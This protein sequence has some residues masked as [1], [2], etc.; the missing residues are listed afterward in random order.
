MNDMAEIVESA[1]ASPPDHQRAPLY[2]ADDLVLSPKFSECLAFC[3]D[4]LLTLHRQIPR[5]VRYVA[6][7]RRWIMTHG[8]LALNFSH[9][10]NPALPALSASNLF[11]EISHTGIA[12]PNTVTSYL[13]EIHARGYIQLL[14]GDD[15]R[16]RAYCMTEFSERMFYLYLRINLQ[17]LNKI[18]GLGRDKDADANPLILTLMH[19]I[20]ARLMLNDQNY[21]MPPPSIA[22][23]VNTTIGISI[24]NEMTRD[25]KSEPPEK[26][27]RIRVQMGSASSMAKHY[28]VSRGNVSRLLAKLQ[29]T[30]NYGSDEQGAWV[31]RRLL[32]D[33]H[34][35]QTLK[36]AHSGTAYAQ[37]CEQLR[38]QQKKSPGT[39][40]CRV[41]T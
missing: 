21:Y 10:I 33:Y 18:D 27:N 17:A 19:P 5:E 14:P 11:R 31:S 41:V 36:F 34:H 16:V 37:A 23:L 9:K 13:Q 30:D 12:S 15:R 8:A 32:D 2:T 6:D 22:P 1:E 4:A 39:F 26:G 7:I 25:Q 24:L 20:F 29:E 28:G 40:S 3:N 35:W 38:Q